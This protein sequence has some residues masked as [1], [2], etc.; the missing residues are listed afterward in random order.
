MA[1]FAV[2]LLFNKTISSS[3]DTLLATTKG[4]TVHVADW[5]RNGGNA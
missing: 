5:E 2:N 4:S 3:E 1:F